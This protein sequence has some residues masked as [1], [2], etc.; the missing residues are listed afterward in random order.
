MDDHLSNREAFRLGVVRVVLVGTA[1]ITALAG[2]FAAR[3]WLIAPT[4]FFDR[5]P[6][7]VALSLL[8]YALAL[9]GW[10]QSV[11]TFP[12]IESAPAVAP[13]ALVGRPR[14]DYAALATE[15]QQRA[16]AERWYRDP[17]LTLAVFAQRLDVSSRTVS[18]VIGEGLG[19][20]FNTL[21]NRLRVADVREGLADPANRQELLRL[22]IDAGFASKASFNRA[23]KEATGASPSAMRAS[24]SAD[25]AE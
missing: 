23:F 22:A 21:I 5:F 25:A 16:I 19:C 15:W 4:D 1:A 9:S 18:R 10:Q 2:A 12:V 17:S 13:Q 20:T 11:M 6:M 7:V 8:A 14:Q 24:Q 3:S